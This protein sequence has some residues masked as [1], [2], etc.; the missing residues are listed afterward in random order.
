MNLRLGRIK[1]RL[2]TNSLDALLVTSG[3]NL[4]Y[5]CGYTGSNGM[6]L[7]FKEGRSIF[8]TDFRYE[9]QIKTEL[10]GCGYKIL[11]RNLIDNF[12]VEDLKRITSLGFEANHLT[13]RNFLSLKKQLK[14]KIKLIPQENF[15]EQHRMIK[16]QIE[17]R[18]IR[19]AVTYTDKVFMEVLKLIKPGISE[20]DLS[21]EINYRFTKL[22]DLSFPTIVAFGENSSKP[23][24]TPTMRK[25]KKNDVILF[26]LGLR[27]QN[28]CADMTRTVYFGRAPKK[29]KEIYQIVLD[30]QL[31]AI[32]FIKDGVLAK[33]VDFC[34]REVIKNAGFGKFFG[35]GLGHGV[36]LAVHEL[37]TVS[38]QSKD[39]L[40]INMV[41]TVEPGIYLPEEFGIRIED[42]VV[43][44]K[45][46]CEVYTKTS[47]ELIEL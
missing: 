22:G 41:V 23:H 44:N 36:G 47:K 4:T 27:Y 1:S 21:S 19:E 33:D 45:T 43:V 9:E 40:K 24:A 17:L 11:N 30:A 14:S 35:H 34:A 31:K 6:L 18:T 7:V 3:Y 32:D 12:P 42:I 28:Y 25:L 26:D 46:G 38:A 2:K 10:K 5:L 8:Y 39:V 37:P 20:R 15:V 13:Y 16:D 29:F